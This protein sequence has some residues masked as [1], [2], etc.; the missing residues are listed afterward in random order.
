MSMYLAIDIGGTKTLLALFSKTGRMVKKRKFLTDQNPKRFARD[1][2]DNL[3]LF[4]PKRL[5]IPTLNAVTVAVAATVDSKFKIEDA[6]LTGKPLVY[7]NLEWKDFEF[8]E[9]IAYCI[10]NLFITKRVKRPRL[11]EKT[12]PF[13]PIT[14]GNDATL[15]TLAEAEG[16][17][18]KVIYLTYSTG[19]GGGIWE[20][21]KISD[22]SNKYEPGH[23]KYIFESKW[24]EY[25]DIASANAI[26]DAYGQIAT[27]VKGPENFKDIAL[28]M[29]I[30]LGDIIKE[31]DPDA[32]II[33]GALGIRLRYYKKYLTRFLAVSLGRRER[34]L[35]NIIAAKTPLESVVYGCYKNGKSKN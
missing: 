17:P 14:I 11:T 2:K 27:D 7:G 21:G 13:C 12:L 4:F 26:H 20:D 3:H 30:G 32:I 5:A 23:R 1:L 18:G 22:R 31:E 35:P 10:N 15:A 19:I 6:H 33:G 28:R 8:A 29:S 9:N 34:D 16:M 24:R 25:E